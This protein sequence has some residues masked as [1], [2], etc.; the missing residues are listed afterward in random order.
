[1]A[2][3]LPESDFYYPESQL[4]DKS[5]Y[6]IIT[7]MVREKLMR[8]LGQELPHRVAVS[9]E[10]F[11]EEEDLISIHVVIWAEKESHKNIVIGRR[12]DKIKRV[13]SEARVDMEAFFGKK[14]YLKT[15][16]K[17]KTGWHDDPDF[18]DQIEL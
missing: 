9:V 6:F 1:M 12:G 13:G 2:D 3:Y 16:V 8:L 4:T 11:K 15:W 10:D 14:V 17:V 5:D 18:L 7:E